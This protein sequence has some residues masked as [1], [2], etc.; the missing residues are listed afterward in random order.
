[1]SVAVYTLSAP[2]SDL[3]EARTVPTGV[4]T[5]TVREIKLGDTAGL[6][7]STSITVMVTEALLERLGD[8]LS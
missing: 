5:L 2:T 8:R 4:V 6:Y 7:L 3:V 1:M